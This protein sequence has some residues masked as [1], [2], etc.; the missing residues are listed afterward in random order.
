M[1]TGRVCAKRIV[2]KYRI[3]PTPLE[4]RPLLRVLST[5]EEFK[6][7]F[8]GTRNFTVA[9]GRT[10]SGYHPAVAVFRALRPDDQHIAWRNRASLTGE[11]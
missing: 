9:V 4:L 10:D 1:G 11:A 7:G 8:D 6:G 3:S 5:F 2:S